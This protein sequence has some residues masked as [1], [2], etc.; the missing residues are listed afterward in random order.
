MSVMLNWF[1]KNPHSVIIILILILAAFLRLYNLE[2]TPGWW[3][4]EGVY[5][6]IAGNLAHGKTQMFA[7]TYPFVPHPPLFFIVVI[8]FIKIFG[9]K[10]LAVRLVSALAG[11]GI[12]YVM[13]LIGKVMNR[14]IT[15]LIAAFLATILPEML[16]LSRIGITYHLLILFFALGLYFLICYIYQKKV[17]YF[18]YAWA[19]SGL[20]V[21]T[22]YM[23]IVL[24][25]FLFLYSVY[26]FFTKKLKWKIFLTSIGIFLVPIIL[27]IGWGYVFQYD[28]FIHDIK[29]MLSRTT[30]EKKSF[31]EFIKILVD[32]NYLFVIGGVGLFFLPQKIRWWI[33]LFFL[34]IIGFEYKTRYGFVWFSTTYLFFFCLGIAAITEKIGDL[35]F[36]IPNQANLKIKTIIKTLVILIILTVIS[37]KYLT[38]DIKMVKNGQ[39]FDGKF[40]GKEEKVFSPQDLNNL[41]TIINYINSQTSIDDTVLASAHI[42]WLLTAKPTDPIL[43][44]TYENKATINFPDD[45]QKTGRFVYDPSYKKAKYLIDDKFMKNWFMGQPGIKEGVL[46]DIYD[47]W[48]VVLEKGEFKIYENPEFN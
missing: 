6:N 8:P 44:Y 20:A 13:Y 10:I 47:N 46:N 19:V 39:W 22:S 28:S 4:D 43:S 5:L 31:W 2:I 11:I 26:V 16:I 32:K 30:E 42:L 36:L 15:G 27:Y 12:I 25:I 24:P 14:S 29:Y 34:L 1:K 3:P 17:K 45:M 38:G 9:Y 35:I 41:Q 18:Y 23:G 7:F 48:P 33:I 21:V 40:Y 37:G